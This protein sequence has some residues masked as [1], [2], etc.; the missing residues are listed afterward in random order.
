MAMET[1]EAIL[2]GTISP[3]DGART[4]WWEA[5]TLLREEPEGGELAPFIGART[6]WEEHSEAR[7]EIEE[8]IRRLASE[9]LERWGA[10]GYF[11]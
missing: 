1:C 4:I 8:G 2:S 3:Q 9:L 11:D 7:T 10:A 6:E 5:W